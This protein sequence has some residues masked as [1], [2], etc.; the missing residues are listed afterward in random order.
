M[1]NETPA[2]IA[3][4]TK[5]SSG[6]PTLA[7]DD[8]ALT[9]KARFGIIDDA[10]ACGISPRQVLLTSQEELNK[11]SIAPGEL[12]ENLTIAGLG[13]GDFVP[14]SVLHIGGSVQIRLTFYCEPC[15]RIGHLV[16]SLS[17]IFQKR[18]ILGVVLQ[19][20]Q[21]KIGD[22]VIAE[23]N[24]F[25]ALSEVPYERFLHYIGNVPEGKV[26]TYKHILQGIGVTHGYYRALPGYI[27]RTSLA[28]YPLHRI[29]DTQGRLIPDYVPDQAAMLEAEGVQV[30]RMFDTFG[31]Q[32]EAYVD[33]ATTVWEDENF[34]TRLMKCL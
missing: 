27:R 5:P 3:L 13:A 18:G 24:G 6:L 11:F 29:V 12:L 7:P 25:P 4:F 2:I 19:S 32:V 10:N 30:N 9:V 14:G 22:S 16:P 26:V 21:I 20:G 34:Y 15:K 8:G 17:N 1:L 23:S 31:E 28:D 33:I